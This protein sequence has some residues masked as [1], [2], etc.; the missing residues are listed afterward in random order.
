MGEGVTGNVI[1][2]SRR[3]N[4]LPRL[5]SFFVVRS[6]ELFVILAYKCNSTE[7]KKH[8]VHLEAAIYLRYAIRNNI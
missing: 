6:H 1:L 7:K 4:V 8:N 5:R 2:I 3:I